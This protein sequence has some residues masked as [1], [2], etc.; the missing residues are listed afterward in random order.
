[1]TETPFVKNVSAKK[2]RP[3]QKVS[4]RPKTYEKRKRAS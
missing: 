2:P 3:K 1:L 4:K